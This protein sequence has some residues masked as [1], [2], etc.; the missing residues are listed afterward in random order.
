MKIFIILFSIIMMIVNIIAGYVNINTDL[1][2][3]PILGLNLV[4]CTL[5]SG[6]FI[7][8]KINEICK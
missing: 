7:G 3:Q 5:I 8:K 6:Y 1:S 2:M 4:F